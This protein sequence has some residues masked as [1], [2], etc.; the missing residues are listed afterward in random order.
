MSWVWNVGEEGVKNDLKGFISAIRRLELPSVEM[1]K[2]E[3]EPGLWRRN[4][5]FCWNM[6]HLRWLF[7]LQEGMLNR[8]LGRCIWS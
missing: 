5:E 7:D 2:T 3:E 1:D 4:Q 8:Q 6:L